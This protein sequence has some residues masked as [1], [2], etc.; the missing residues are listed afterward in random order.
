M[1][2]DE[3]NIFATLDL[4][5]VYMEN[6]P[7]YDNKIKRIFCNPSFQLEQRYAELLLLKAVYTSL[8]EDN[9]EC[10]DLLIQAVTK[11]AK[12]ID[13]LEVIVAGS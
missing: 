9:E 6:I 1:E 11:S 2:N 7:T 10:V 12:C 8:K 3:R 5:K 4:L 13:S